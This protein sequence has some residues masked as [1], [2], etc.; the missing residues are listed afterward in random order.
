MKRMSNDCNLEVVSEILQGVS[1]VHSSFGTIYFKHLSQGEQREILSK[2]K[3][4][5]DQ[6]K[7]KGL[8]KEEE[9]L[10]TLNDEG[11][12]VCEEEETLNKLRTQAESLRTVI[13]QLYLPSKRKAVEE[14]LKE[15]NE[16]ISKMETERTSILGLTLEQ[17]VNSQMQKLI[18]ESISFYDRDF[19]KAVFDE[20][21]AGDGFKEVEVYRLQK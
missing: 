21:Y 5:E 9:M 20:I 12:W 14:E 19:T 8:K 4:I 15:V 7:K 2:S 10:Q 1:V 13:G 11:M 18:I 17:Y 16:K 3:I 6:A